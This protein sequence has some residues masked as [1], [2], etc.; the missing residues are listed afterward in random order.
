MTLILFVYVEDAARAVSFHIAYGVSIVSFIH[1]LRSVWRCL[2]LMNA[3]K[4]SRLSFLL[5]FKPISENL[6]ASFIQ[7]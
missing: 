1:L 2:V 4:F 5:T 6:Q 7:L 3:D